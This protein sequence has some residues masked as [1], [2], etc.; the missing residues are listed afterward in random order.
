MPV[1]ITPGPEL[2]VDPVL[3]TVG[4][5]YSDKRDDISFFLLESADFRGIPPAD[6]FFGIDGIGDFL[7]FLVASFSFCSSL[8][9]FFFC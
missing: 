6:D 3:A 9:D 5:L 4:A 2:A 1:E 8:V 7:P